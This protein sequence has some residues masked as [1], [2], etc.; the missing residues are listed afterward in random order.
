MAGGANI[1]RRV[2]RKRLTGVRPP[3]MTAHISN[4]QE[5]RLL[6]WGGH[7]VRPGEIILNADLMGD[8]MFRRIMHLESHPLTY[9]E[10]G[11]WLIP[12]STLGTAFTDIVVDTAQDTLGQAGKVI[13]G[14]TAADF[15]ANN[16]TDEGHLTPGLQSKNRPW[17]G[18]VGDSDD[19]VSENAFYAPFVSFG[20]WLIGESYYRLDWDGIDPGS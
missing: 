13:G 1:R 9:A 20:T 11:V 16:V 12:L 17:A 5:R 15:R 14:S 2:T 6:P 3:M 8:S 4:Q 7:A 19:T 18:E 10:M